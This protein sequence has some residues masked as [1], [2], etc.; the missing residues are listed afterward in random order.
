MLIISGF[1]RWSPIQRK[2]IKH[3]DLLLFSCR[4]F[5]FCFFLFC[6]FRFVLLTLKQNVRPFLVSTTPDHIC[7]VQSSS[8]ETCL[9]ASSLGDLPCDLLIFIPAGSRI[10]HG[11]PSP[12]PS[13]EVSEALFFAFCLAQFCPS[14]NP[15]PR[16][17]HNEN[18]HR[19]VCLWCLSQP[20]FLCRG[21]G[22]GAGPGPV[23]RRQK[24]KISSR[25]FFFW[26]KI[27]E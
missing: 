22:Y 13:T 25:L 19:K 12:L 6:L 23:D 2:A 9:E 11:S 3:F 1:A 4:K 24:Q 8:N 27:L 17:L 21:Q 15:T 10:P 18:M 20:K 7:Q 16:G 5:F 14:R 26:M